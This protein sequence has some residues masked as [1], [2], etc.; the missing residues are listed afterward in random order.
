MKQNKVALI[1]GGSSGIGREIAIELAKQGISICINFS[2]SSD[3]AE[4]VKKEILELGG[5]V[6]IYKAD[7]T[8]ENEVKK[9]FEYISS[10]FNSL[11]ILVNNAGKYIPDFI[12]TQDMKNWEDTFNLNLKGKVLC[13]KYAVPLLKK[14]TSA[15]IVNIATRG[16]VRPMEESV[17]YCSAASAIIM[18]T[19]V[20][21]LELSKY[22]IKVNAVS[23]GLTKTPMTLEVDTQEDFNEYAKKNPL[24]RMGTV[25][26]IAKTVAFLV[27][28][29]AEFINGENINV[30]GGVILT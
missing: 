2:K 29:A 12:E 1:T 28:D 24:K 18:L 17:A 6:M 26:D 21:A 13:I 3:K 22:N 7:I 4:K 9:M 25:E 20:S 15:R 5:N 11:D 10:E 14:S 27:S 23:P 19:Q 30:S 16:A 8:N